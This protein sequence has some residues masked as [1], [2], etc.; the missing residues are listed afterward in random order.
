MI[1]I[2]NSYYISWIPDKIQG[3]LKAI[4]AEKNNRNFYKPEH[5]EF[6][7]SDK[8]VELQWLLAEILEDLEIRLKLVASVCA[9]EN[10]SYETQKQLLGLNPGCNCQNIYHRHPGK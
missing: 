10:C 5:E 3:K 2:P 8:V 4:D 1:I 7:R 6:F 9:I